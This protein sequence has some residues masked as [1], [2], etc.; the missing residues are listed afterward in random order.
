MW[1]VDRRILHCLYTIFGLYFFFFL[2]PEVAGGPADLS[3][4]SLNVAKPET[5]PYADPSKSR[6]NHPF[7]DKT[8]NEA[9]LYDFY[10]RQADYYMRHPQKLEQAR[11][12]LP[13]YPGL[14]A[15]NHGHWGKHNQN[16]HSDGRV[17]QTEFGGLQ[18]RDLGGDHKIYNKAT[19]FHVLSLGKKRRLSAVFSPT[20]FGLTGAW[21]DATLRIDGHRWGTTHPVKLKGQPLW[22]HADDTAK[23]HWRQVKKDG[24]TQ[25]IPAGRR[26]YHGAYR[27]GRRTIFHYELN[28][29]K[30]LDAP[31]TIDDESTHVLTR[32][33]RLEPT[34]DFPAKG[35]ELT[36]L[37]SGSIESEK[38]G[39]LISVVDSG[40][41]TSDARIRSEEKGRTV[42]RIDQLEEPRV[43]RLY[44]WVGPGDR[45]NHAKELITDDRKTIT[46]PLKLTRNSP[47]KWT[48]RITVQGSM[49][50]SDGPLAVD[51]IPVPFDNPYNAVM[52][53]TGIDFLPDGKAA[54]CTLLG[55]VWIV[56][57][58]DESLR[59]VT[60]ERFASGLFQPFGLE[61]VDGTIH[62]MATPYVVALHDR[63]K[64][65]EADYREVVTH[66][67]QRQ[68]DE[69]IPT[70][71]RGHSTAYGLEVDEQGN[72]IFGLWSTVHRY[73]EEQNRTEQLI[74][75]LRNP[76]AIEHLP[77][78]RTVVGG[79]EGT[80]TPASMF[81][82]LRYGDYYGLGGP[83]K[84]SHITIPTAYVPRGVDNSTGGYVGIPEDKWG[85]LGGKLLGLS[86]GYGSMYLGLLD[87]SG[88][89]R[90]Q[91]ASVPLEGAFRSGVV[92]GSFRSR[93]N[94]LYVVGTDGWGNYALDD[95]CLH[96]VR[97]TG[98]PL[99]KPTGFRV[100]RNGIRIDFSVPLKK[101][102]VEQTKNYLVQMWN[103][104]Y[105]SR[106]GSPEFS[107]RKPGKLGHDVLHVRSAHLLDGGKRIFLE[108]PNLR[109]TSMVHVRMHL[110]SAGHANG[111]TQRFRTS[112]FPTVRTL[113]SRYRNEEWSLAEPV[114]DKPD[115]LQPR[116]RNK[117]QDASSGTASDRK[118]A[119]TDRTVL[120][121]AGPGLQYDRKKITARA[122]ERLAIKLVNVGKT[123]PHNLVVVETGTY[124]QV[125]KASMKMLN[126]PNAARKQY[127]PD[128]PAVIAHTD[129]I[130]PNQS[131]IVVFKVPDTPG[132]YPFLCTFPGH[133]QSMRGT[134]VVKGQQ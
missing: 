86:Y 102:I 45:R 4:E 120:I 129:V 106:Y 83:R 125:G 66:D 59:E 61:V 50:T 100:F 52:M 75:G 64:D 80:W 22:T 111:G 49:G 9:R 122:G 34:D 57:G 133:W 48:E 17:N 101:D 90:P 26:R 81:S 30:V 99:Q 12:V 7:S 69:F 29:V 70:R 36:L 60:W 14:D 118:R 35:L 98:K 77:D 2:I 42:L 24:T 65:L 54:V 110:G 82:F 21:T 72:F 27:H 37:S 84:N 93:S 43:I 116:I 112:L 114:Q 3:D 76:M 132:A 128:L 1:S 13:A 53:L 94:A 56:S 41:S 104:E 78:G 117:K 79:Q 25:P 10:A 109:P 96:R 11:P 51:T 113:G 92:R 58:L 73:L 38:H 39:R 40:K 47:E 16:N 105:A 88:G 62:V 31:W 67:V 95:G 15:G 5:H 130:T 107:V 108:I 91:G 46:D 103:Y 68:P 44:I 115:Q 131:S 19:R 87:E 89:R 121:K 126:N 63:N 33:L 124:E 134:L 123:M 85:P 55:D 74:S 6:E 23:P 119:E 71:D 8:I 32:T 18:L 20:A 28:G 127:V 97:Y